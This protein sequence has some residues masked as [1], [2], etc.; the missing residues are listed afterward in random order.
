MSV[1][2]NFVAIIGFCHNC[3]GKK[4]FFLLNIYNIEKVDERLFKSFIHN[5]QLM[6][7]EVF[8]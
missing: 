5:C 8:S 4:M 2:F 1:I 7:F 3:K 6:H